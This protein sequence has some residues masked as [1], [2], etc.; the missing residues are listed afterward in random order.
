MRGAVTFDCHAFQVGQGF[1]IE[2]VDAPA[3]GEA[4]PFRLRRQHGHTP[5][6]LGSTAA[7]S[8][9]T[10]SPTSKTSISAGGCGQ[11]AAR[12]WPCPDAVARHR[13]AATSAGLGD[14]RRGVLYER[15]ALRTFFA[16]AD[17][18]CRAAFGSAVSAT[19]LHRM[20]AFASERPG[21]REG[22]VG[23]LQPGR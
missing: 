9:A 22:G 3:A 18:E 13:G 10:S 14:F 11:W 16:C 1:P 7:A 23:S 4:L 20:T 8:T 2:D 6:R 19:F 15:N 21:T 12:W 17:D 5:H